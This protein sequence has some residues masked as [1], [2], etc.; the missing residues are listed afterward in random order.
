MIVRSSITT[1]Q[2]DEFA[3]ISP[4][5]KADLGLTERQIMLQ[6]AE[7]VRMREAQRARA[8]IAAADRNLEL[9]RMARIDRPPLRRAVLPLATGALLALSPLIAGV[10]LALS[11]LIAGV[12]LAL[13]MAGMWP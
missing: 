13:A 1:K 4:A 10:L 6:R 11:P 9:Q 12:L 7:A 5:L 8:L 3:P 2:G